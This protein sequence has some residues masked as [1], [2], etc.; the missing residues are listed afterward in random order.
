MPTQR[1]EKLLSQIQVELEQM[2]E[3]SPE[4]RQ[5]LESLITE[6]ETTL[7]QDGA[8]QHANFLDSARAKLI[9]MEGDHPTASG[10]ARRLMQALSDMGI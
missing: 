9:E 10:V 4:E 7:D 6:I 3:S 8:E 5:R 2:G 1:L